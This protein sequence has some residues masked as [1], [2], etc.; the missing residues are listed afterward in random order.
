[1]TV[2]RIMESGRPWTIRIYGCTSS[3]EVALTKELAEFCGLQCE[4]E[5]PYAPRVP[6]TGIEKV[7]AP[8]PNQERIEMVQ[9]IMA[10]GGYPRFTA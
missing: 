6:E 7:F 4:P 9:K 3:H 5:Y 2:S 8:E 10:V 1:M